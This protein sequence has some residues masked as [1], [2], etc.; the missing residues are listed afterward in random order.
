MTSLSMRF[1]NP[2]GRKKIL[3]CGDDDVDQ[4]AVYLAS[5]LVNENYALDYIPSAFPFPDNHELDGYDLIIFS[6][7]PRQ[8]IR[9]E[10][11]RAVCRYVDSGGA[12]LM[13]G[14]WESFSGLNGEYT[15]SPLSTILPVI[16]HSGDDRLNYDQGILVRPVDSGDPVC[17]DLAWE[18]PS[19]VGG[20]NLFD[21]KQGSSL[22][23]EGRKMKISYQQRF[24]AEL[25]SE[26]IP[27][28]VRG[29]AGKGK[30]AAL[31]FDLA[32]HWI[33]GF[34]DWGSRRVHVDFNDGFIEV[35]NMYYRFVAQLIESCLK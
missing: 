4:A 21:P 20:V 11:C 35:G 19:M 8:G 3:F 2:K 12:F 26:S 27:L 16:M 6:D 14:G 29:T 15:D 13:I 31:A 9:D 7:Y 34:V 23:L 25:D 28:F 33:G 17:R 30:T 1:F 32:P 22:V 18:K 24:Q 5:I 10:Q